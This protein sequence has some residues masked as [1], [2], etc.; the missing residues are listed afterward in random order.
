MIERIKQ[1]LVDLGFRGASLAIRSPSIR[2]LACCVARCTSV[3]NL[4]FDKES[5]FANKLTSC[6]MRYAAIIV[7]SYLTIVIRD[8]SS[9][10]A[11]C[12]SDDLCCSTIRMMNLF[13][14]FWSFVEREIICSVV[15]LANE[16]S[17]GII[18]NEFAS[19]LNAILMTCSWRSRVAT[20]KMI[21]PW[22]SRQL[23][24]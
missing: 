9:L 19:S 3:K 10:W 13:I 5:H 18:V 14:N 22:S 21:W 23:I 2:G 16:Y 6:A 17:L 1:R 20:C 11:L 15:K 24:S 4:Y 8:D 12:S 7:C